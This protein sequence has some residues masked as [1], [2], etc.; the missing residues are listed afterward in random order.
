M[1][2]F[3]Y[4]AKTN[5]GRRVQGRLEA[6]DLS[7]AETEL[8]QSHRI[9]YR[10][11][12]KSESSGKLKFLYALSP[13]QVEDLIGFS[14]S[15][16]SMS[17]SGISLKRT[18]DI[19]LEDTENATMLRVLSDVSEDLSEGKTLAQSLSRH[20]AIFP[21]YYV[22]M[23]R[24][25]ESSGNLPEMMTRLAE[26]L[27]AVEALESRAKAALSYPL[28]L[29][30]FTLVSFL[31][32]FAYGSPYLERIYTSLGVDAPLLTRMLLGV[33]VTLG[34]SKLELFFLTVAVFYLVWRLPRRENSRIHF[35]RLR[36]SLPIL[37]GV[38]RVL[39]TARFI[40][41]MSVLYRSGLGLAQS[42]RLAAA[43]IG[44]YAIAEELF[45]LS[46]KLEKGEELSNTLRES[47]HVSRM[48]VGM[49]AAG[50]ESGKLETMLN[51]VAEVYEVKTST[52]MLNVRS[53]LEPALM[54]VLGLAVAGLLTIMGWPL[55]Q[56][57]GS[58]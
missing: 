48:A 39:Y 40:R 49:I 46:L 29:F 50:E 1:P 47:A 35:D 9:V 11:E 14:Q 44:N 16:A 23:T 10:I 43:A 8:G 17:D 6:E 13:V 24:A 19:L 18:I 57:L 45:D 31:A 2:T 3:L 7:T 55:I 5:E 15:I 42:V 27:T 26:I 41:T 54:L 4:T 53:R 20:S 25:G 51:R 52:L 22:A 34:N 12:E 56:L 32:F 21:S 38:F 36:L 58:S 37:G 28:L 30:G 33:G